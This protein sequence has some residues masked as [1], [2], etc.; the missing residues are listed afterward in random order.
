LFSRLVKA[1]NGRRGL[2][3]LIAILAL[4][5]IIAVPIVV[6]GSAL[7]GN[8]AALGAAL[9][10]LSESGP[11]QLPDWVTHI[12][13]L[14]AR[15][16]SQWHELTES[17]VTRAEHLAKLLPSVGR[18]AVVSSALVGNGIL[19]ILLSLVIAFFFY[20]DGRALAGALS[21]G[22]DRIGGQRGVRLLEV[23]ESSIRAVV[24]GILGTAL[25]QGVLA[26]VEFLIAGI[27]GAILLGFITFVVAVIPA[28]PFLVAASA[29][30]WA[31]R[32][33]F[34]GWAIFVLIWGLIVSALDNV[35]RPILISR[36]V[37]T[38]TLLVLLGVFGGALALG[39]V[40]LF[41][42]PRYWRLYTR[43]FKS[44]CPRHPVPSIASSNS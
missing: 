43:W 29:A 13:I 6:L 35:V 12:P 39:L 38:P 9:K 5:V 11:P 20:R 22:I 40:G 24:Y 26:A 30:Y 42:G 7:V 23:A 4:A 16:T 19:Q 28:G 14:G 41:I 32:Q 15:L 1:L 2:A 10:K 18:V 33:G 34:T 31:Y 8:I 17:S 3:A 21:A 36:G 44:G 37:A 27:P 25:L